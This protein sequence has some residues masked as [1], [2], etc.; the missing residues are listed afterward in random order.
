VFEDINGMNIWFNN[1]ED[2]AIEVCKKYNDLDFW[3]RR[4][5]ID[6]NDQK[7]EIAVVSMGSIAPG[8]RT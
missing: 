3:A 5:I 1:F 8:S 7:F 6:R 2:R 4:T